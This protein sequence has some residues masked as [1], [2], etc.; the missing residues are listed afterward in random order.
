MNEVHNAD[1][2]RLVE[3]NERLRSLLRAVCEQ[4]ILAG[5]PAV[6]E[7]LKERDEHV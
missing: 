7:A 3:E 2:E 1:Y 6:Q 4:P 5:H